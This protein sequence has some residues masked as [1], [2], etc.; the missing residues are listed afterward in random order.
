MSAPEI[1]DLAAA[2]APRLITE[3]P[4]P[5]AVARIE[6]DRKVTSPS[7]P[8]AYPFV[9]R[10]GAGSVVEDVD[11][12]LFLDLNAGIAVTSTGHAHPR[13]VDTIQRQ[14]EELIHYSASDFFLPI[15]TDVCERLDG[16]AG[17]SKPAR[18]FL[19]NSGTEAVEAGIKLARYATGRQYVIAFFG[20][21]HGRSYGSVS[22]T[23]SKARYRTGFGPLLPGVLH[24]FFGDFEYLE[25]VLFKRLVSPHEVAAIVVEPILGE[26]G[27]V[28]PPE[29]WFRYLRELCSRHGILLVADEVQSGMGRTGKMWAIQHFGAE[30]DILLVGKGIA[31]GMPLGAMVARD[32]LMTWEIG[33]HGS[34]YGGNPLSCAAALAT[35]DLIEDGLV[36]NAERMGSFL[37]DGLREIQARRPLIKEVRGLGLMIGIEFQDHDTMIAVEQAAFRRGLLVLGAGDDVVRMCPPLVFR[38]DQAETA[39]EVFEEAVAEAGGS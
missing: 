10:R 1:A 15:Y 31:S 14:A 24:S 2:Q 5:E 38:T 35:I 12:N 3:V 25:E 18:S 37:L 11:G 9:P 30:P 33:A 21:F 29:G 26:G 16:I 23:A 34:T 27:Y 36:E 13:V 39:L 17:M 20:S 32:D 4:G 28:L 6:R 7:L 19:T 8:R 22:L